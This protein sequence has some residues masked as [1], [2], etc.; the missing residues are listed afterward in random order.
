MIFNLS[1]S[2]KKPCIIGS[3]DYSVRY[4]NFTFKNHNI[5]DTNLTHITIVIRS[6]HGREEKN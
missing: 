1:K 5:K 2:E 6:H 3:S 4:N